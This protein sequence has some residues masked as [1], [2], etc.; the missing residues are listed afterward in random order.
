MLSVPSVGQYTYIK[1][2]YV[3]EPGVS[4]YKTNGNFRRK[5][6]KH[7]AKLIAQIVIGTIWCM[8]IYFRHVAL[9]FVR[10]LWWTVSK[11]SAARFAELYSD[12][13][14]DGFWCTGSFSRGDEV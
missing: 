13:S 6:V 11:L 7:F 12:W 14:K 3:P 9:L 5:K 2:S 4:I 10:I 8:A 1:H